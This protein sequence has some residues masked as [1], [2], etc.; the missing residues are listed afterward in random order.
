MARTFRSDESAV[1]TVVGALLMIVITVLFAATIVALSTGIGDSLTSEATAGAMIDSDRSSVEIT[2]TTAGNA[3][4]VNIT[5]DVY[6]H[7]AASSEYDHE[8]LREIDSGAEF[9]FTTDDLESD[10]YDGRAVAIAVQG[11]TE[12]VVTSEDYTLEP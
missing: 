9:R 7:L 4:Y 8:D 2:V 11:D 10:G 3:D 6:D 5:G 12:T 1:S